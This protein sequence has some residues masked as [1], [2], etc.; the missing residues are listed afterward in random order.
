M[1]CVY[2]SC[3]LCLCVCF[4]G[5]LEL[6]YTHGPAF[7]VL[8]LFK[9]QVF[10][11]L[12]PILRASLGTTLQHMDAFGKEFYY[13]RPIRTSALEG[14]NWPNRPVVM[15]CFSPCGFPNETP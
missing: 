14:T 3:V 12:V 4:F 13:G 6:I 1:V 2:V 9:P 5:V 10:E 11:V 15:F 7:S 8:V